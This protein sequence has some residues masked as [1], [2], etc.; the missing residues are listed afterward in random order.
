MK[1]NTLKRTPCSSNCPR[2]SL[3]AAC[4]TAAVALLLSPVAA[5]AAGAGAR[6][7]GAKDG[8]KAAPAPPKVKAAPPPPTMTPEKAPK[9]KP[10]KK[11]KKA[12]KRKPDLVYRPMVDPKKTHWEGRKKKVKFYASAVGFRG[13]VLFIPTFFLDA[14]FF[15][16]STGVINGTWTAEYI[17][18][19][20]PTFEY[21]IGLG[22]NRLSYGGG[23]RFLEKGD[24]VWEAEEI[25]NSLSALVLDVHFVKL[26]PL[27][28][29]MKII[30][31]GGVGIG[32]MLGKLVRTDTVDGVTLCQSATSDAP[33]HKDCQLHLGLSA[34]EDIK[35]KD[36]PSGRKED[37]VPPVI[38]LVDLLVGFLFQFNPRWDLR[39]Q[40]GVGLPRIFYV[41]MATH[42]YF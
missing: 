36:N 3:V 6:V 28:P 16:K 25:Q 29:G 34:D 5:R 22:Y 42:F 33:L 18:R 7:A 21:V 15:D 11:E 35:D 31:G 17:I 32:V 26:V 13:G 10:K 24:D 39:I 19:T 37:R 4:L 9:S 2:L 38:P 23:G 41:E 27:T 30:L 1:R 8:K 12:K 14:F 20:N 40:G